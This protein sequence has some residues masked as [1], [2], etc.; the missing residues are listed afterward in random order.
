MLLENVEFVGVTASVGVDEVDEIDEVVDE[1]VEGLIEVDESVGNDSGVARLGSLEFVAA[2]VDVIRA[3]DGVVALTSVSSS[4]GR[5][6]ASATKF[7]F[8]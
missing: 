5:E 4:L 7:A 6:R 3:G 2:I 1:V 8:P